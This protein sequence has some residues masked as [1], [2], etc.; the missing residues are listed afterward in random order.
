MCVPRGSIR[1]NLI[2]EKHN[3]RISG[4][5]GVRKTPKLVQRFYY[6]PKLVRDVTM[7]VEKFMVCMKAKGGMSNVGLY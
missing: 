7:Y 4:Y 1:E 3:G 6:W 5:F 2:Q